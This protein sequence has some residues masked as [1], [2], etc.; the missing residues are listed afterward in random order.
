MEAN[1]SPP[2]LNR[3]ALVVTLID[4]GVYML[5]AGIIAGVA[6]GEAY[7][8]ICAIALIDIGFAWAIATERI[9]SGDRA[10]PLTSPEPLDADSIAGQ[11]SDDPSYEPHDPAYNPENPE[12][13]YARED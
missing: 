12:N 4:G 3:R 13:P 10:Q 6:A 8:L 1:S 11:A 5:L 7:F 9:G 2:D